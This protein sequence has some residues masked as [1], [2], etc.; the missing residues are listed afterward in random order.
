MAP[1]GE[2]VLGGTDTEQQRLLRQIEG[3]DVEARWLLDRVGIQPGWRA[4][5]IGCGPLGILDR[6]SERVGPAG[7]VVGLEREP[8][9]AAMGRAIASERGLTNVEY[10]QADANA[11]GLP[12]ASFDFVHERLAIIQQP[13]PERMLR[14][15]VALARPGGIVAAQEIDQVSWLCEPPHPAW[16]ALLAALRAVLTEGGV[17]YFL[18]RKLPGLL[19]E[20]GLVDVQVE[21][22]IKADRPGEYRRTHLL[23]MTQSVREKM[24]ARGL[25]TTEELD[26]T[27]DALGRHLDDPNTVVVRQLLFQVWGRKP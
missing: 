18:G 9:F 3:F 20:A 27:M 1:S 4:I 12:R 26:A 13:D 17:D 21:M 15:M 22:Q 2:Y 7:T 23:A 10:V 16:D 11:T 6:L 25:F 19:R 14:E 5:D 24:L 8:R